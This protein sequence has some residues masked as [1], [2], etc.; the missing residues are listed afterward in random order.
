[1]RKTFLAGL[2]VLLAFGLAFTS[3]AQDP[4]DFS[5]DVTSYKGFS[6]LESPA[7]VSATA[8]GPTGV[9][10]VAWEPVPNA[11]AYLLYRKSVDPKGFTTVQMLIK[12]QGDAVGAT[13]VVAY[14]PYYDDIMDSS[15][16]QFMA[17]VQYTYKVVAVSNWSSNP[18]ASN[19]LATQFGTS[20]MEDWVALQNSSKDS[21]TVSFVEKGTGNNVLPAVGSQLPKPNVYPLK[22]YESYVY[23]AGGVVQKTEGVEVTFDVKP[24]VTYLVANGIA[25]GLTDNFPMVFTTQVTAGGAL[26]QTATVQIPFV[27]GKTRVEVIA[28]HTSSI[29][30]DSEPAS[31]TAEFAA[32]GVPTPT[33]FTAVAATNDPHR[34]YVKL[35]WNKP[36]Y[37]YQ[38]ADSY[39]IYRLTTNNSAYMTTANNPILMYDA[40]EDVTSAVN[41]ALVGNQYVAMD[42]KISAT[43]DSINGQLY[44]IIYAVKGTKVSYPAISGAV[45]NGITAST[46]S[47]TNLG[48]DSHLL[49]FQGIL[50][51]WQAPY[52]GF[53]G[54]FKLYRST[55]VWNGNAYLDPGVSGAYTQVTTTGLAV[56]ANG[57]YAWIDKPAYRKVYNYKLETYAKNGDFIGETYTANIASVPYN[58]SLDIRLSLFNTNANLLDVSKF[59]TAVAPNQRATAYDIGYRFVDG[60]SISLAAWRKL[61]ADDEVIKVSRAPATVGG[62]ETGPYVTLTDTF[63]AAALDFTTTHLDPKVGPGY[64]RYKVEIYKG[65]SLSAASATQP[66][67]ISSVNTSISA[68]L[69]NATNTINN[70]FTRIAITGLAPATDRLDGTIFYIR[71]AYGDDALQANNNIDADLH[72]SIG[73]LILSRLG[74]TGD[75]Y[76]SN[77]FPTP[78]ANPVSGKTVVVRVYYKSGTDTSNAYT[79]LTSTNWSTL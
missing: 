32:N 73:P 51:N 47:Y 71:Y 6:T 65:A 20:S 10:R 53:D 19:S 46:I 17:G 13:N 74:S 56:A 42:D 21:N 1:M 4:S 3:C 57:Q 24:G 40:W 70:S 23:V 27:F 75:S 64:Y 8:Y 5:N 28:R 31:V 14:Q 22:R 2:G 30:K 69:F 9:I 43:A 38:V 72:T 26:Q 39:K 61:L 45:S 16:N 49:D 50:L 63:A 67:V 18:A 68:G 34:H 29:F 7:S 36:T 79:L 76:E 77:A 48:W 11:V 60:S 25:N 78:I 54:T 33:G 55:A 66:A 12:K 44:Y 58:N 15:G 62:I 35:T 37:D 41:Y 59:P 52:V